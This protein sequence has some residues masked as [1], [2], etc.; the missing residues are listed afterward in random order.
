MNN[1]NYLSLR[2]N[3]KGSVLLMSYFLITVLIGLGAA[4]AL[5]SIEEKLTSD[6]ERKTIQAANIAEAGIEQ[7][8]YDL[9]QD[10]V[11]TGA[12]QNWTDGA[13]NGYAFTADGAYH[14]IA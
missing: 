5:S 10:F 8:I 11:A 14:N 13:V 3:E 2:K 12:T 6:K 1:M 7:A 4:L 9:R